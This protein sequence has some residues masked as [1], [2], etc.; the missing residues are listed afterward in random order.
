[1]IMHTALDPRD[2]VDRL[3]V[4]RKEGGRGFANIEDS[5]HVS[6]QRLEDYN[7]KR[8]RRLITATRNYTDDTKTKIT[9]ISRQQKWEEKQLYGRFNWLINDISQNLHVAKKGKS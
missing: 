2:D 3:Y 6:I 5:V 7:K 1:M 4:P 8:G 9:T